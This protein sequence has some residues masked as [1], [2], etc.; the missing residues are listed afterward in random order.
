[1]NGWIIT[2]SAD[3]TVRAGYLFGTQLTEGDIVGLRG[4]LGTGKTWF[5]KGIAQGL[6]VP[7]KYI[8]TS[9]SF[10]LINEYPGRI[11]LYHLDVYR[12][13]GA[14]DLMAMGYEEVFFSRGVT[15]IE[16][17]DKVMDLI[18]RGSLWVDFFY[19]GDSRRR[20]E[21]WG[22]DERIDTIITVMTEGRFIWH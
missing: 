6:Q 12:L 22:P 17:A 16:W 7:E 15:V 19:L 20:L 5:T 8:V 13:S 1:M 18:P 2:E 10:V 14:R 21:I 3:E 4:E 9:P 11:P